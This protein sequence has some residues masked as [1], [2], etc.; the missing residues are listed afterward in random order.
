MFIQEKKPPVEE[1]L[2]LDSIQKNLAKSRD[3]PLPESGEIHSLEMFDSSFRGG[4][5][6]RQG[7]KLTG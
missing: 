5:G 3:Q 2:S 4:L 7:Q 6:I 1:A